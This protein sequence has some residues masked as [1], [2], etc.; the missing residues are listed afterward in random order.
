M[1]VQSYGA[2][3]IW[4]RAGISLPRVILLRRI[5]SAYWSLLLYDG[6]IEHRLALEVDDS[7][8]MR[9]CMGQ[10]RRVW[11]DICNIK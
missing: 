6:I 1:V 4:E 5:L 7:Q 10:E 8:Y 3:S 9:C 11:V 2:S